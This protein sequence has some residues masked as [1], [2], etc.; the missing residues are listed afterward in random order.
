[1]Q[2][3]T[4]QRIPPPAPPVSPCSRI[5]IPSNLAIS[6]IIIHNKPSD[7]C[8][9]SGSVDPLQYT[10][11]TVSIAPAASVSRVE[12]FAASRCSLSTA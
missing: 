7:F 4:M 8:L 9:I 3:L 12:S 1:M 6:S 5:D 11:Y 2:E 10:Q